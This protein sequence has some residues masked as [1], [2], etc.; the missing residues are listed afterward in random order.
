MTCAERDLTQQKN[1]ERLAQE[2]KDYA[3]AV[4][5]DLGAP[6]RAMVEFSRLLVGEHSAALNDEGKLFLSLVIENG[7]KLQKMME[8]LLDYSRL[9]IT[10]GPFAEVD[11]NEILA[12]CH[13][14]LADKITTL[15]G[16]IEISNLPCIKGDAKQITQLFM[17]L[18]DNALKFQPRYQAPH[19]KINAQAQGIMWMFTIVD[20]GIGIEQAYQQ[21]IFQLF[22]R[23]HSDTD[24][25]GI[26]MGLT[27][28]QKIVHLHGGEISIKP[29][30]DGG[31]AVIFTLPACIR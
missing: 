8:G 1:E 24:Y 26:G 25:P 7:E 6:V 14:Q 11:C 5:H 28:A 13:K 4:S 2:F 19:I 31:T 18:L 9:N 29:T 21:K 12:N 3:Y 15:K 17:Y 27:L 22:Q 16:K 23:L 20:N 10:A 30:A